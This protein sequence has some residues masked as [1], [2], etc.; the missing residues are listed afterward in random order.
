MSRRLIVHGHIGSWYEFEYTVKGSFDMRTHRV[1]SLDEDG[2]E[3]KLKLAA[4]IK[5]GCSP[6]HVE[7]YNIFRVIN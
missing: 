5:S 6:D 3:R 1:Q 4:A 2:L 7:L